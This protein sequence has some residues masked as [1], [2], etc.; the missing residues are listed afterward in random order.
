MKKFII[1]MIIYALEEGLFFYFTN[2]HNCKKNKGDCTK[3]K[4]W[5]CYRQRY[6]DE[7][8]NLKE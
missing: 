8:G 5:S 4:D 3:C 6:L 1:F 2:K 7:N